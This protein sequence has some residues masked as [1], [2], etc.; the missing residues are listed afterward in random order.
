MK[1]VEREFWRN[2]REIAAMREFIDPEIRAIW[3]AQREMDLKTAEEIR[4]LDD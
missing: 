1:K 4:R 3:K 2:V